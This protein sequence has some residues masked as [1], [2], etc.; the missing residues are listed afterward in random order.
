M[1]R[2]FKYPLLIMTLLAIMV[3][4]T[5]A[6]GN[7][8]NSDQT[9]DAGSKTMNKGSTAPQFDLEDLKGNKMA[10]AEYA[11][12]KVYVKFWASWCSICLAGLDE[13]NTLSNQK[14]KFQVITIVSPDFRG[15]LSAEDFTKWFK[16]Q[17]MDNI[18]VLLDHDGIWMQKYGVRGYPTSTYIG[19]DGVLVKSTPGHSS[20]E[21]ITQ[22]FK[23]IK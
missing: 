14:N 12:Q 4:M 13:L 9:T 21:I 18:T 20:N 11:G 22:N 7:A 5:T 3:F 10:L 16:K 17:K 2:S 8:G 6:C 23:N 15:E 1:N 19:S